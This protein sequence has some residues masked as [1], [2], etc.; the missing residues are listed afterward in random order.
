M[1][2]SLPNMHP[3]SSSLPDARIP[4]SVSRE[5]IASIPIPHSV[6]RV[7]IQKQYVFPPMGMMKLEGNLTEYGVVL[8]NT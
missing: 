2:E 8:T 7:S 1:S 6:W 4:R 3:Y 5:R